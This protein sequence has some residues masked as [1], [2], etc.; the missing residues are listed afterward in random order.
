[1]VVRGECEEIV[2]RL[3]DARDPATFPSIAFATA[4]GSASPAARTPRSFADLP[5]LRWPDVWIAR[6]ITITIIVST[7]R[8]GPG[9]E[10]E[11]SRGCP[12]HCCFCAKIDFRDDYRRRDLDPLL[13]EIDALIAQGVRYLYFIDEIFLPQRPLLEALVERPIEF[14]IQTRIDL[15]K[16]DMLDLLG[17]GRLRFDRG[18][19]SK[20]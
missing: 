2:A 10:V 1:M 16:P 17:R 7:E 19:A 4:A 5:A 13:E 14:G 18:R 3:A 12:Y 20:A 11:A 9:A 15:W 6:A 8:Q